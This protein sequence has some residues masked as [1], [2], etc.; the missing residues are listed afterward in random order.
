MI[1]LY[2]VPILLP[3]LAGLLIGCCRPFRKGAAF[4]ALSAGSAALSLASVICAAVLKP[5]S[6]TI[7]AMSDSL[8]LA[9]GSDHLSALFAI[10]TDA[11]WLLVTVYAYSYMEHDAH[12]YRFYAWLLVS[13]GAINGL[14]YAENPVTMYMFFEMVTLFS[15][16]LVLQDRTRESLSAALKYLLYSLAGAFLA[17]FGVFFLYT[18]AE[19][20]VFAAGGIALDFAGRENLMLLSSFFVLIGFGVKA[21]LFPLHG[22][23]PTAHPVAPAPAS[24]LLSAVIT[25]AGVFSILRWV[26]YTVG[27]DSIRGTWVQYAFIVLTLITVFMGSMMAFREEV[28]KKRL[29]YSTVSQVSYVLL[30]IALLHPVALM[31]AL[32]HVIYHSVSKNTLF[33]SA[34]SVI[35]NTGKTRVEELRGAGQQLPVTMWCFTIASVTLVGIP[36]MSAFYSKWYLAVGALSSG[37]GVVTWLAPVMLLLS[38][39]LTAG[40]L[41]PISIHAFFPGK[42]APQILRLREDWRMIVPMLLLAAAAAILGVWSGPIHSCLTAIVEAVMPL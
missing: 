29:A 32:M 26:F 14:F 42:D 10:L 9:L 15:M 19:N 34:G 40:Y 24:A 23:L 1:T 25:K 7:L 38:A 22:W 18:C 39:L 11:S 30:G 28:F 5:G 21:G 6:F 3:V 2:L 17:L 16:P 35:H 4:V 8:T 33:L 31:G 13:L 41:L 20:P 27:A 37:I 36:P 12:A